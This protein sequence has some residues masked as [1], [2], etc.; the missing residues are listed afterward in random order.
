MVYLVSFWI[1]NQRDVEQF[2]CKIWSKH[3]S[4]VKCLPMFILY[5]M[6]TI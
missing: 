1:W 2:I 4:N 6:M 5:S 3:C